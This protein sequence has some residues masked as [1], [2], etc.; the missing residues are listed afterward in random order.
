MLKLIA[1]FVYL[2]AVHC[3]IKTMRIYSRLRTL[4]VALAYFIRFT[5][6]I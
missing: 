6:L 4:V 3:F 5:V 1:Q 2:L